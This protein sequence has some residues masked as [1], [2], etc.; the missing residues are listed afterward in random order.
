[1]TA[2]DKRSTMERTHSQEHNSTPQ[3]AH[4]L[5]AQ[6][7]TLPNAHHTGI[8]TAAIQHNKRRR[9]QRQVHE[10][11]HGHKTAADRTHSK[12]AN[13]RQQQPAHGRQHTA[14]SRQQQARGTKHT[15]GSSKQA[16]SAMQT[17]AS[18]QQAA[19]SATTHWKALTKRRTSSTDRPTGRSLMVS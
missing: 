18:R 10:S 16:R 4:E 5:R 2:D 6:L 7:R 8:H 13:G 11:R 1:M 17:A 9:T 19:G 14:A 12:Q 3:P 15:A